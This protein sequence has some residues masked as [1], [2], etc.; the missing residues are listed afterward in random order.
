M[1]RLNICRLTSL[2][3]HGFTQVTGFH[4]HLNWVYFTDLLLK[5]T[6]FYENLLRLNQFL[7]RSIFVK[8]TQ[9]KWKTKKLYKYLQLKSRGV[10]LQCFANFRG[11]NPLLLSQM[12][13]IRYDFFHKG[14]LTHVF[15]KVFNVKLDRKLCEVYITRTFHVSV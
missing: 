2:L 14:V 12:E 15:Y 7:V 9:F 8:F 5:N 4:F 6:S 11:L 1:W 3:R 13:P 10:K